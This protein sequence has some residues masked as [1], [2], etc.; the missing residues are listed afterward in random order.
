MMMMVMM[1]TFSATNKS[2]VNQYKN[3]YK[4][5]LSTHAEACTQDPS[6]KVTL[7]VMETLPVKFGP[8]TKPNDT[9]VDV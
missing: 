7:L 8:I 1:P 9:L 3:R 2:I 6:D 4:K 5:S